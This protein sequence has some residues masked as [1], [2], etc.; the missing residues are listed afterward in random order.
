MVSKSDACNRWIDHLQILKPLLAE[1]AI[2]LNVPIKALRQLLRGNYP[3]KLSRNSKNKLR[4][5]TVIQEPYEQRASR[6]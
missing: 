4:N 5:V 3:L 6:I 1:R 2:Q